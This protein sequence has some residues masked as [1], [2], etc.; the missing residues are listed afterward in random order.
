MMYNRVKK[1][2]NTVNISVTKLEYL[3]NYTDHIFLC[4]ESNRNIISVHI[5]RRGYLVNIQ[6]GGKK[7]NKRA[8]ERNRG[9]DEI[10][11]VQ[12]NAEQYN[13]GNLSRHSKG[14]IM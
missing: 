9:M 14:I 7:R 12:S 8:K 13:N 3:S 10:T 4:Q 5:S 6:R 11:A 1:S 2:C